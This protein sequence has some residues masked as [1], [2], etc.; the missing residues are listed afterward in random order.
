M[1]TDSAINR[2]K[3][4]YNNMFRKLYRLRYDNS[5]SEMFAQNHTRTFLHMRRNAVFSLTERLSVSNNVIL[6]TCIALRSSRDHKTPFWHV[7]DFLLRPDY[8]CEC[9]DCS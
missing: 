4:A 9:N 6:R 5:A 2:F 3:V 8:T 1:Y 7:A